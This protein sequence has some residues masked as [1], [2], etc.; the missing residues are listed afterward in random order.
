MGKCYMKW[1]IDELRYTA[2]A[3]CQGNMREAIEMYADKIEKENES[4]LVCCVWARK[5]VAWYD[6]TKEIDGGYTIWIVLGEHMLAIKSWRPD[7]EIIMRK[8][9]ARCWRKI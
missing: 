9:C 1:I 6:Y 7:V 5:F 4:P 2:R 8:H 3:H